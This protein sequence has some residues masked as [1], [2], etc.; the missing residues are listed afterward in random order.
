MG[1]GGYFGDG[2]Y[3]TLE[4]V[5]R[6]VREGEVTHFLMERRARGKGTQREISAWI[7]SECRVVREIGTKLALFNC[8]R[9]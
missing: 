1:L 6:A 5:Q 2:G 7:T 8:E 3:P 9:E 4:A